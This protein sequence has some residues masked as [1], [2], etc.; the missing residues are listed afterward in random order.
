MR[1]NERHPGTESP[2]QD[3]DYIFEN[4]DALDEA[5]RYP[6]TVSNSYRLMYKQMKNEDY[7]SM[8]KLPIDES[9]FQLAIQTVN[10][11]GS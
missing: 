2:Q 11:A 9:I 4:D 5:Y 1:A 7:N 10:T 3:L 8:I 6:T